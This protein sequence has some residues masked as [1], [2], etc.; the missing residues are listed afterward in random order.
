MKIPDFKLERFFAKHEFKVAHV[1]CSSDCE[2]MSV[3][4]LLNLEAGA[5]EAFGKHW[6]GYTEYEGSLELRQEITRLYQKIGVGNIL[7]HT[8]AE[9]AIFSF[10][11]VAFEPGD[12]LIVHFP[13]Y[14]SLEQVAASNGCEVTRWEAQEENNWELDI[15]FLEKAVRPNTKAIV[16]NTPHNPTGYLMSRAKLAQVV[17]FARAHKLW[18]FSDEVYQGMEYREEDRLPAACD[19][20]EKA[21]SLGVMSKTYGLAGLRIGWIATQDEKLYQKMMAFKDY[22]SMCNSAPGEFLATLALRQKEKIVR[23]NM[24]II[25]E[26][27]DMLNGFFARYQNLFNWQA[28]KAGAIA[29]PGLKQ[30]LEA[31]KFCLD[32]L[33]KKGVLLLPSPNYDFG[34]RNFRLGFAR[35][36]MP[37]ALGQLD[38]YLQEH[39]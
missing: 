18:L 25:R 36:N 4:E 3:Q 14:Q 7:V 5:T 19:L 15:A 38:N 10:M 33:D 1:L 21:V 2:A 31:E 34:D 12:H 16:I 20:Y 13:C 8:G 27:L 23:R 30:G 17:D 32:L 29:F 26:N 37:Q 35:R 24:G 39:F 6:L 22:L 11:N 28:P 9:E